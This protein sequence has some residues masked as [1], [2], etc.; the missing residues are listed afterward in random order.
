MWQ[1]K[2]EA[3]TLVELVVTLL[4]SA[5]LFGAV[6]FSVQQFSSQSH[7]FTRKTAQALEV[8]SLR[9][10]LTTDFEKSLYIGFDGE[11]I[12]CLRDSAMVSYRFTGESEN[13]MVRSVDIPERIDTIRVAAKIMDISFR[14]RTMAMPLVKGL[15]L[16]VITGT[17]TFH[18]SLRRNYAADEIINSTIR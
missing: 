6:Y 16:E 13:W 12:L 2:T 14:E 4:I 3:F 1:K 7:N 5:L 18:L 15:Q 17:D 10:A 8:N 11:Y 9:H